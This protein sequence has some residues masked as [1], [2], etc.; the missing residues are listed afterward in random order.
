M[1]LGLA[2]PVTTVTSTR[3]ACLFFQGW[4]HGLGIIGWIE[5]L[6][7][8]G[9][10]SK[11]EPCR[12]SPKQGYQFCKSTPEGLGVPAPMEATLALP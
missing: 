5:G 12:M 9:G 7:W 10:S 11:Q 6:T 4:T 2:A 1:T 8:P 3:T